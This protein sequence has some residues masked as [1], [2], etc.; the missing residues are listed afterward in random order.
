MMNDFKEKSK[1]IVA[2][3][4]TCEDIKFQGTQPEGDVLYFI[5]PP[6][7]KAQRYADQFLAKQTEPIQPKDYAEAQQ[8]VT[9]LIWRWRKQRDVHGGSYGNNQ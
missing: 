1:D 8:T 4:L 2:Y 7:D 5:F 6:A 3:L 9:D